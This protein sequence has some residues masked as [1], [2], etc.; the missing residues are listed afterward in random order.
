[1]NIL[2][3]VFTYNRPNLL[4]FCMESL[5]S[6]PG[7]PSIHVNVYD[8]RSTDPEALKYLR[9]LSDVGVTV[10]TQPPGMPRSNYHE[11]AMRL[12]MA[13]KSALDEFLEEEF[14]DYLVFK[15]DDIL[16]TVPAILEAI[17]D[18]EFLAST[19]Y[20]HIGALTMHGICTHDGSISVK[21]KV[22]SELLITGEANVIFG[23]K[24]LA[25]VGNHLDAVKGGFADTQFQALRQA[26]FRYY[27]RIWPTYHVQHLGIG[28]D[29]STIHQRERKPSWNMGLYRCTYK[30]HH[31]GEYL[32]VPHPQLLQEFGCASFEESALRVGAE[33]TISNF[34]GEL[35]P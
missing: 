1:M 31:T 3:A 34:S 27:D 5:L 6:S 35:I 14:Y 4:K 16:T 9:R 18:Y 24:S 25:Q 11:R 33:E 2:I 15:D 19:D 23:R 17:E 29:G 12:A 32:T 10:Y 30:R 7:P 22:F 26:G 21:G 20:A 28:V 8:D 13:R